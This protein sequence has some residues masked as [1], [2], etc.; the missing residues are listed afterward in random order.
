MSLPVVAQLVFAIIFAIII[1]IRAIMLIINAAKAF[2]AY[3]ALAQA[4]A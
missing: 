3:I 4:H 1:I 2:A